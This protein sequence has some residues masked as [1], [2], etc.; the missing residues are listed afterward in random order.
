MRRAQA[1]NALLMILIA[2]IG[3]NASGAAT[4]AAP[5]Q[6]APSESAPTAAASYPASPRDVGIT[7]SACPN[8]DTRKQ[9]RSSL[10]ISENGSTW[11]YLEINGTIRV[12]ADGVT[13]RCVRVNTSERYGIDC[14][15]FSSSTSCR[16][17]LVEHTEVFAQGALNSTTD[18][19]SAGIIL[20][21]SDSTIRRSFVEGAI[22]QLKIGG[23]RNSIEHNFLGCSN[24]TTGGKHMDTVQLQ[25]G[26]DLI[27]QSNYW[28]GRGCPDSPH[29]PNG[30]I[31][32]TIFV[33]ANGGNINRILID[34]NYLYGGNIPQ[35]FSEKSSTGPWTVNNITYTNN[36]VVRDFW[37]N[38]AV[39]WGFTNSG[40]NPGCI[41]WQGNTF[42][43]GEPWLIPHPTSP[44][45]PKPT[46]F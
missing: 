2:L 19:T 29:N 15:T 26:Q 12:G 30:H 28:T 6:L 34:G 27:F 36:T 14:S 42:H 22:D 1:Q 44:S 17:L 31:S 46:Q 10:S 20:F 5:V 40:G 7:A 35:R 23:A 3:A 32:G 24:G 33:Q 9:T 43:D 8:W 45:C 25:S 11:E 16:N 18:G 4:P 21:G 13:L 39:Y 38:G 37:L 41:Q